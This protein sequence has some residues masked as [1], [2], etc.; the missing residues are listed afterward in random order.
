MRLTTTMTGTVSKTTKTLAIRTT[1]ENGKNNNKNTLFEEKEKQ[2]ADWNND[3]KNR[4]NDKKNDWTAKNIRTI[5][6]STKK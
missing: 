2:V 1:K 5:G 6:M 3:G 4:Y